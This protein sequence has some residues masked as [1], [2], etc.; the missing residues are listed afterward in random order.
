MKSEALE[1]LNRLEKMIDKKIDSG[2]NSLLDRKVT[3]QQNPFFKKKQAFKGLH[4]FQ[5][6][7]EAIHGVN[8]APGSR[9]KSELMDTVV[10]HEVNHLLSNVLATCKIIPRPQTG[11]TEGKKFTV[12]LGY[13]HLKTAT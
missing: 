2:V 5:E 12:S 11:D 7:A 6:T 10:T 3:I 9:P 4:T 1:K 8:A 13:E